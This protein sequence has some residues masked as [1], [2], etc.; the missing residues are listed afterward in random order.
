MRLYRPPRAY[1]LTGALLLVGRLGWAQQA[2]PSDCPLLDQRERCISLD[3]RRSVDS[4]ARP[5]V[6]RWRMGDGQTREGV[7]F[8]YC[9][10]Q[11]GHY[12]VHLDVIDP[13]SGEVRADEYQRTLDLTADLTPTL[14]FLAP[15]AVRAG[16]PVEFAL[17]V[18]SVP[19]CLGATFRLEWQFEDGAPAQG[20]RVTHVFRRPGTYRVRMISTFKKTGTLPDCPLIP[21][22]SQVITVAP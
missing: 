4:T 2:P 15:T 1:L 7:Q 8:D 18:A 22:V 17:D 16:E 6:F 14:R 5:L 3:A 21:C 11:P 9:Y 13:Q 10:A 20:P 19:A 12:T